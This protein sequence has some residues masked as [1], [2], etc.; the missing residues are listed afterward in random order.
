MSAAA[1]SC[2]T[3]PA[4]SAPGLWGPWS[5][6]ERVDDTVDVDGLQLRRVGLTAND[7]DGRMATGSAATIDDSAAPRA[8]YELGERAALLDAIARTPATFP[9]RDR[10]GRLV[11]ITPFAE[12]F[13]TSDAPE[14]WQPAKSSGVAMGSDWSSSC[15]HAQLELI[16]RDRVLRSWAGLGPAPT[17]VSMPRGPWSSTRS[18]DWEAYRLS[19]STSGADDSAEV[20]CMFAFPRD[21]RAPLL[22]GFAAA[23]TLERALERAM[24]E[25]LQNLAFLWD[26]EIPAQAPAPS[27]TPLYHL[28]H[29]L[30]RGGHATLRGW[31]AGEGRAR[32]P[33]TARTGGDTAIRFV[34]LTPPAAAG[35][36]FVVRALDARALAL[37]FG[38][39]LPGLQPTQASGPH[40]IA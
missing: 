2:A 9:N 36:F 32:L 8:E 16:E 25:C 21:S 18:Y 38:D 11:G 22:R 4:S 17:R 30:W 40:P 1:S 23:R 31:L 33:C 26:E 19:A 14:R 6:C 34:D 37:G 35:R 15:E 24:L 5:V 20:A 10:G 28:D 27:P 39:G 7:A 3:A 13:P 29:Y 12:V